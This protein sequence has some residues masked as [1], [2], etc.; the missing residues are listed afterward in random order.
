MEEYLAEAEPSSSDMAC[1]TDPYDDDSCED[2]LFV[3]NYLAPGEVEVTARIPVPQARFD[4]LSG[5]FSFLHLH[6]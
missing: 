1:Q 6:I 5:L 4:Y 2:F 3:C